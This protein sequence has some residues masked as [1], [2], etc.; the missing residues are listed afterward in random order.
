MPFTFK[1][2]FNN[3]YETAMI[4]Q[5]LRESTFVS[6]LPDNESVL[7]QVHISGQSHEV[8]PNVHNLAFGPLKHNGKIDDKAEVAHLD[9]SKTFSTILFTGLTYLASNPDH[10]LGVDGSD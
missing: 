9:Y 10:H 1:I 7:L 2:D 3:R 4:S 5:N 8:L 6:L